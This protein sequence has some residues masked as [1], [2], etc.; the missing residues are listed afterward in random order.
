VLNYDLDLEARVSYVKLL[1]ALQ[2]LANSARIWRV[3]SAQR[4]RDTKY[5]AGAS[6]LMDKKLASVRA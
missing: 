3:S 6:T 4:S 1:N 2:F 5:T